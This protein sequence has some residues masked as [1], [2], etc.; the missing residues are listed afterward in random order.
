MRLHQQ[1]DLKQ[2]VIKPIGRELFEIPPYLIEELVTNLSKKGYTILKS[3]AHYMGIP[4][5]IIIVKEL[6]GPFVMQFTTKIKDDFRAV[7][8]KLGI[9][10]L[11]E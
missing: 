5:S 7:S 2:D 8:R 11:F 4:G 1:F 10:G 6:T 3:S 9:E